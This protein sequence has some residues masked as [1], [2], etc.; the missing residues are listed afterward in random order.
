MR[1]GGKK[2]TTNNDKMP[3]V[4][5]G[6]WDRG[7]N[8]ACCCLLQPCLRCRWL[9]AASHSLSSPSR[10]YN[11]GAEGVKFR[12]SRN[13]PLMLLETR[14]NNRSL[15]QLSLLNVNCFLIKCRQ[16]QMMSEEFL[17]CATLEIVQ[18]TAGSAYILGNVSVFAMPIA[19]V[20]VTWSWRPSLARPTCCLQWGCSC[21]NARQQGCGLR[22]RGSTHRAGLFLPLAVTL[23]DVPHLICCL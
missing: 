10:L 9:R 2:N 8:K 19:S 12:K 22:L 21:G 18:Q 15:R 4:A 11:D 6:A 3:K 23:G 1:A 13:E 16:N 14:E 20:H 17:P 7:W 5:E